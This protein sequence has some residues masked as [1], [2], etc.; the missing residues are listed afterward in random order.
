MLTKVPYVGYC[1]EL[2]IGQKVAKNK[3][4]AK[5]I[6]KGVLSTLCLFFFS[7]D[8]TKH[9]SGIDHTITYGYIFLIISLIADGLLSLKEK[10]IKK[11]VEEH[12]KFAEYK[13]MTCWYFM[14]ILNLAVVLLTLPVY[15]KNNKF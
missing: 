7:Y 1:I 10:L 13:E 9:S 15:S 8:P 11:E 14:L 12:P 5:D 3:T 4:P 6:I 2:I